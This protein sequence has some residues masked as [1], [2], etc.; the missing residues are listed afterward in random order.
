M[1]EP[2]RSADV[3]ITGGKCEPEVIKLDLDPEDA[4]LR[5][6]MECK[7]HREEEKDRKHKLLTKWLLQPKVVTM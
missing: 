5:E 6:Y 1:A 2:E 7:W 4:E 3:I